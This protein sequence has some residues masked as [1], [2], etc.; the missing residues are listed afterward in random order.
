MG[1]IQAALQGQPYVIPGLLASLVIAGAW[2]LLRR[3]RSGTRQAQA[4]AILVAGIGA[5]VSVCLTPGPYL[6]WG[7]DS[8]Q[9]GLFLLRPVGL[10]AFQGIDDRSLNVWLCVP[11]GF[12]AVAS[13]R[14]RPA[15]ILTCV[16]LPLASE[17]IQHFAPVLMHT[18]QA[19]DVE[20]NWQGVLMGAALGGIIL[21][22]RWLWSRIKPKPT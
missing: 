18:C 5:Y 6:P 17:V 21:V 1:I 11:A 22:G 7:N 13:T 3:R 4:E 9:C 19:T 14:L 12:M 8:G 2:M 20:D 15:W 16:F 10:Q